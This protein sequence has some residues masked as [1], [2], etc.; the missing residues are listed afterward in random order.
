MWADRGHL[1]AGGDLH[2]RLADCLLRHGSV[3]RGPPSLHHAPG[4][5]PR[6]AVDDFVQRHGWDRGAELRLAGAHGRQ[7]VDRDLL[8]A[9]RIE[10]LELREADPFGL[11]L[12]LGPRYDL[13][14]AVSQQEDPW[15]LRPLWS[16]QRQDEV[17]RILGLQAFG[18]LCDV[19]L[20]AVLREAFGQTS[21]VTCG[22]AFTVLLASPQ[23][24]QEDEGRQ[25][26][27]EEDDGRDDLFVLHVSCPS[28]S[29]GLFCGG[30]NVQTFLKKV[31]G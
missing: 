16:D 11:C 3:F 30:I 4:L 29:A 27:G 10:L 20:T 21:F 15:D 17:Q 28:P 18:D 12:P 1:G 19:Q 13:G 14:A 26:H 22:E 24:D 5:V 25:R 2:Q 31:N 6:L 7:L 8:V 23:D 9:S